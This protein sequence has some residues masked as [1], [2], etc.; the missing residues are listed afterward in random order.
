MASPLSTN[1]VSYWKMQANSN[2]SVATNNGTDTA[3]TYN[4]GNGIIGQG[5][6]YNGTTSKI[7][8]GTNSSLNLTGNQSVS[9]WVKMGAQ[10]GTNL[11]YRLY[12]NSGSS[13]YG[14]RK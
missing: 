1:L 7:S 5:A 8:V 10:P 13:P 4:T 6:G 9:M 14:D 12:D 2:D 11:Q 3:I